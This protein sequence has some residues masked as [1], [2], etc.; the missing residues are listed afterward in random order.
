MEVS[1]AGLTIGLLEVLFL[2]RKDVVKSVRLLRHL[3]LKDCLSSTSSSSSSANCTNFDT[4]LF[5]V[6]SA[7]EEASWT[8][9]VQSL[10][11]VP[12]ANS[13][14]FLLDGS[15]LTSIELQASANKK[16][17]KLSRI[18]TCINILTQIDDTNA[19]LD[20]YNDDDYIDQIKLNRNIVSNK[21][22]RV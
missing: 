22:H 9:A 13:G 3:N 12:S 20:V 11:T 16:R 18:D 8:M 15:D 7:G 14:N 19:V 10:S 21:I 1:K 17:N 4:S 5:N 2:M 6:S